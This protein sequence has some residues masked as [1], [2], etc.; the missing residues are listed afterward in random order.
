M[1]DFLQLV[2][3]F[4]AAVNPAGAAG[5]P[6]PPGRNLSARAL[7]VGAVAALVLVGGAA[8]LADPILDGLGVEPETFRVG[9]GVVLLIGGALAAWNGSAPHRGPWEGER[10]A[11]FPLALPVLATPAALAAAVSF[12]ADRGSG[13]ALMAAVIAIAVAVGLLAARIGRFEAATDGLA[14]V[15]GGVLVIVAAGL[16]VSGVRAI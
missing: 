15:S 11:L 12:G 1:T 10:S 5:A 3:F 13:E 2:V 16:I 8:L 7:G 9:A 6:S 14:R 4:L